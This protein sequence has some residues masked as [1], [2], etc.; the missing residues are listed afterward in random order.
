MKGRQTH[1]LNINTT[2]YVAGT[3]RWRYTFP[4]P[5][6]LRNNRPTMSI[7]HYAVYNA[8]YNI[9]ASLGNNTFS[10]TWVDGTNK[11]FT[12]PDGYYDYS[13]LEL[14]IQF[15][16][17]GETWYLV[18]TTTSNQIQYYLGCRANAVQYKAELSVYYVPSTMPSGYALPADATWSLPAQPTYPQITLSSGLQSIFGLTSQASFP[19]SQTIQTTGTGVPLNLSF[20]S[21]T[22]PIISPVYS[23]SLGCN[24]IMNSFNTNPQ[25]FCQIPL[26]EEFGKLIT[27]HFSVSK[28][29]TVRPGVYSF[30]EIQ[31][32][33]QNGAP[34]VLI[35]PEMS[36][37]LVLE[38]DE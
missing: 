22:Y 20:L 7:S 33:D 35:D 18:N 10:I 29:L 24:L 1:Q 2:H 30:I 6:D 13:A 37:A 11:S 8:T 19:T 28:M 23:Y 17:V 31:M 3:N 15:C 25:L 38:F 4:E 16:M 34:L 12:I 32:Y 21:N 36:L 14:F 5:L 27:Q 9:S 26:T